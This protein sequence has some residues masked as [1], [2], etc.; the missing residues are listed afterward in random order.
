MGKWVI[1]GAAVVSLGF[2]GTSP[3]GGQESD[4]GKKV[5]TQKCVACHGADGKG[6][7][8]MAEKLKVKIEPLT[9]AKDKADGELL[10]VLTEGKKPMPAYGTTLKKEELDA[11]LAYVKQLVKG[12][13]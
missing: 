11:V 12:G 5:Y 10:R 6:N 1:V 9:K 3:A 13:N 2:L 8:Q 7:A 4:V